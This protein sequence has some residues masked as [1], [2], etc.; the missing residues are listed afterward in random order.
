MITA[1]QMMKQA[2]TDRRNAIRLRICRREQAADKIP[3]ELM[4]LLNKDLE[5]EIAWLTWMIGD[6]K[7]A[8]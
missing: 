6:G 3:Q 2:L 1:E 7:E 8:N 4:D 5:D